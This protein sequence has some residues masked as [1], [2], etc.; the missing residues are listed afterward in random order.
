[1]LLDP[2]Q[3]EI[4]EELTED[5]ICELLVGVEVQSKKNKWLYMPRPRSLRL[6]HQ[7]QLLMQKLSWKEAYML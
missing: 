3:L 4:R 7:S 2:F 5:D 1:M 6:E